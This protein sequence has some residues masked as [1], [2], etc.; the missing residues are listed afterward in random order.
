MMYNAKKI[1][2]AVWQY[3]N[4]PVTPN[5]EQESVWKPSRFW[6]L[7]KIRLLEACWRQESFIPFHESQDEYKT[8]N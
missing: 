2:H 3:L 7:Y 8:E 6:Y 1:S 4:Q 5:I